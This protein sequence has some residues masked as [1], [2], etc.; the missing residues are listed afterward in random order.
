V[1]DEVLVPVPGMRHYEDLHV[2]EDTYSIGAPRGLERTLGQGIISGLRQI[3]GQRLVQTTT[4][5]S[6]GSSG[7]GLFDRSGNLVGITTFKLKESEGLN[8]AI[9]VD[10][11]F[12]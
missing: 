7:G 5:I 3:R 2:G 4:P 8:F 11:F 10:E 1:A 6:P 9:A 12:R